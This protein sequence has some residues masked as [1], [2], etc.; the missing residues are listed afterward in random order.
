MEER[1]MEARKLPMSKQKNPFNISFGRRPDQY[2]S[3]TIQSQK[4]IDTFTLEP[5]TEQINILTGVRG[6]G[7]TITLSVIANELEQRKNWIVLRLNPLEKDLIGAAAS[8]LYY[9]HKVKFR[10]VRPSFSVNSFGIQASLNEDAPAKTSIIYFDELIR[11]LK[12]N[13]KILITIDE[14]TNTPQLKTF[15]SY[16]QML[17]SKEYPIYL[18]MTGLYEN[19]QSLQ[20]NKELT[21]LYRAPKIFLEPLDRGA[22]SASYQSVFQ[23]NENEAL[24]LAKLTKGYPFA[25]QA[26]GYVYWNNR[27]KDFLQII[28]EYDHLLSDAAYSKIWSELSELDKT[29]VC[30]MAN[31]MLEE[32]ID[33]LPVKSI[34]QACKMPANKFSVYRKRLIEKG[35]IASPSYGHLSFALPRFQNFVKNNIL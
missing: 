6:S 3:R 35:V 8:E 20:D 34:R 1:R 23:I 5:V 7:K 11:S 15:S 21:F 26:L 2:I 29:I 27:G 19:V 24:E 32:N 9:N 28:T 31:K 16:F 14:V 12:K 4:I 10:F 25:F 30:Q 33:N 22:M 17:V 18:L 13:Q